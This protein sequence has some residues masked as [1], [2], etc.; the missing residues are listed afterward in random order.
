MNCFTSCCSVKCA[1]IIFIVSLNKCLFHWYFS[2]RRHETPNQRIMLNRM[3]IMPP[4]RSNLSDN[5]KLYSSSMVSLF[6]YEL[7]PSTWGGIPKII[8]T[9]LFSSKSRKKTCTEYENNIFKG[10]GVFLKMR[11]LLLFLINSVYK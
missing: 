7:I 1:N 10:D 5:L 2:L 4:S 11:V 9:P 3:F 6:Y 8:N